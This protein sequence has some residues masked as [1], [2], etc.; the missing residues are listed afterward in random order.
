MELLA[1]IPEKEPGA[2][3]VIM[4]IDLKRCIGCF[5]CETSCKLEHN[6]SMGPRLMRV[7]QVGPKRVNG[8]LKTL[9]IPMP[10]MHCSPAA[11]VEAC[12]TGAMIKRAKDGIVYV[13]SEKCIGCK[14]CMQ[15]C[16]FGAVQWDSRTNKVI[17]C[18]YCINRVD[19]RKTYTNEEIKNLYRHVFEKG[20]VVHEIICDGTGAIKR[21]DKGRLVDAKGKPLSGKALAEKGRELKKLVYEGLWPACVTK[22][23]TSAMR[24]GYFKDMK[25]FLEEM[26][27]KRDIK[28]VGSI[29][30]ALPK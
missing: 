8:R 25:G 10:C 15:A 17:K 12:P 23:S 9:Y 27:G 30:Y 16:P 2:S 28:R 7:M 26:K 3:D 4:Y 6:V 22:C 24:F 19:F 1:E 29:Y 18:D 21:D 20:G 14:R 13:D 11:C 5:G